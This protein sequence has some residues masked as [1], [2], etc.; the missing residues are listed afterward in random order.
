VLVIRRISC[1]FFQ[2]RIEVDLKKEILKSQISSKRSPSLLFEN[3]YN[4]NGN[5]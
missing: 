1:L 5:I 4:N 3:K 2:R